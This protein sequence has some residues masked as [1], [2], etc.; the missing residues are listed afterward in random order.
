MLD[1]Y[2]KM[3][4]VIPLDITEDVVK[5]VV[6]KLLGSLGPGGTNSETLQGWILN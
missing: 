1:I 6:W 4:I 2:E 5:S 3:P